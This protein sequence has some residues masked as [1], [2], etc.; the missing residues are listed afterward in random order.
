MLQLQTARG[1]TTNDEKGHRVSGSSVQ[2]LRMDAHR[3]MFSNGQCSENVS[4]SCKDSTEWKQQDV[5][6]HIMKDHCKQSSLGGTGLWLS[7]QLAFEA[8]YKMTV[9]VIPDRMAET[10]FY[11][12][13]DVNW[14]YFNKDFAWTMQS[15][16]T[17]FQC[18]KQW[19]KR[20]WVD[21]QSATLV[22]IGTYLKLRDNS[23]GTRSKCDLFGMLLSRIQQLLMIFIILDCVQVLNF[24]PVRV[25]IMD[26]A[27]PWSIL[28]R[29]LPWT[30]EVTCVM[31]LEPMKVQ[32]ETAPTNIQV[33]Q[34]MGAI[35][36]WTQ[37]KQQQYINGGL[38]F[39]SRT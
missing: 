5:T 30:M 37:W 9:K 3:R 28:Y 7:T 4:T 35:T 25:G 23:G 15:S 31:M 2:Q 36:V 16:T 38:Y 29:G 8:S 27:S 24:S 22:P 32:K 12:C 6:A 34:A 18:S 39:M 13:L 26:A 10:E 21:L 14:F 17:I 19:S 33:Q 11:A 1:T 20:D